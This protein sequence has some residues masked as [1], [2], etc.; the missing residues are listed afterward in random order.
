M[1]TWRRA[2]CPL[3]QGASTG[4]AVACSLLL[5]LYLVELLPAGPI[6]SNL[7]RSFQEGSLQTADW[8][9]GN[10]VIGNNQYNDRLVVQMSQF[11]QDR[12]TSAVAPTVVFNDW[13][14]PLFTD[15]RPIT[16]CRIAKAAVFSDR[17][18]ALSPA[19]A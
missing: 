14:S 12:W 10:R 7:Q 17:P 13:P 1:I 19:Q 18:L 15:G 9:R 11:S 5:A 3:V 4:V 8:L 6:R 2:T 16:E